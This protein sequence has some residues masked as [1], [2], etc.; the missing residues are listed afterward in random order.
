MVRWYY[1]RSV[2]LPAPDWLW[3]YGE[4]VDSV[5]TKTSKEETLLLWD[6][7]NWL[8]LNNKELSVNI[9]FLYQFYHPPKAYQR[10]QAFLRRESLK[11]HMYFIFLTYNIHTVLLLEMLFLEIDKKRKM[12]LYNTN[13]DNKAVLYKYWQF[14]KDS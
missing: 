3:S 5:T 10:K 14:L 4:E 9:P 11:A 6:I 2:L 13:T 7:N 12:K 8:R 1:I